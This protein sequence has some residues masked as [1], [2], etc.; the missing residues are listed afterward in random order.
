[1]LNPSWIWCVS[2]SGKNPCLR[3]QRDV[4]DWFVINN[5][6]GLRARDMMTKSKYLSA[7]DETVTE[8]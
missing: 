7:C 1:M 3:K 2:H 8:F 5:K 6:I 4:E